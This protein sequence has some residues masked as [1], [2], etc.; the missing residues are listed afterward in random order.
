[1]DTYNIDSTANSHDLYRLT[2]LKKVRRILGVGTSRKASKLPPAI[3]TSAIL[4]TANLG[5]GGLRA[6]PEH[7]GG[8]GMGV[9]NIRARLLVKDFPVTM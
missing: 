2:Q 8:R 5:P 1:M 9:R 7:A 4:D 6:N 3:V